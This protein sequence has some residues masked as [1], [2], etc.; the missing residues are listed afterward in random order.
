MRPVT[1][2]ERLLAALEGRPTD[3]V[4]VW[5][6]F[7]F[8]PTGY[9]VDVR[10]HPAYRPLHE[11]ALERCVTLNRRNPGGI[12][13]LR[14]NADPA[15]TPPGK[16]ETDEDLEAFCS[17]PIETDEAVLRPALDRFAAHCRTERA[18]F[19]ERAGAMMLDLGEPVGRLYHSSNLE[20]FA[21][22]SLTH[23]AL[24]E[25]YLD[26]MMRH[27]RILY[28]HT[29]E[30]DLADV[31]FLVGSELA[32]PP[33]V[34]LE[35]FNRWIVPYAQELTGLVRAYGKKSI[36]HFHGQIRELL[37][38]FRTMGADALHTIEAPPVGNCTFTQAYQGLGNGITLIGN[39][40]YDDFRSLGE[41]QMRQAVRDVLAECKGR[42]LIL[43]PS[44]GP[45][46][47]APSDA[48]VRN[49]RTFVDEAWRHGPWDVG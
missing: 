29:L 28:R 45:F 37:P 33:L 1:P 18:E 38:G 32:A 36:Q 10:Q 12:P 39:I 26:R 35:V 16:I 11:L 8:H 24:I 14:A 17:L 9:Y 34:S 40:Q 20:S 13:L 4:P 3:H 42:R 22:W 41:A 44:A 21:I 6:L 5:L 27:L 2:R 43:S 19:P 23:R 7:P 31:Y 25:D 46:D 48:F 15:R 30:H 47:P 49:V